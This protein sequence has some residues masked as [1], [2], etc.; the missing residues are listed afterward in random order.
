M[1][2]KVILLDEQDLEAA[3]SGVTRNPYAIDAAPDDEEIIRARRPCD[4]SLPQAGRPASSGLAGVIAT[5]SPQ[6]QAEV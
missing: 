4:S 5:L 2:R 3:A 1:R 6:P